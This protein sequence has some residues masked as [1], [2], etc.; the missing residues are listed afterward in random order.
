MTLAGGRCVP[1]GGCLSGSFSIKATPQSYGDA[2]SVNTS[3][4]VSHYTDTFGVVSK[5]VTSGGCF[6]SGLSQNFLYNTTGTTTPTAGVE[7]KGLSCANQGY[8]VTAAWECHVCASGFVYDAKYPSKCTLP[9]PPSPPPS[10]NPPPSPP[11]SPPPPPPPPCGS[12]CAGHAKDW[13]TKCSWSGG[14]GPCRGCAE[15]MSP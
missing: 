5:P 15:C 10:P 11:H 4:K 9:Q 1:E 2:T 14:N 12:W 8:T 3:S 6:T 13:A 7:L